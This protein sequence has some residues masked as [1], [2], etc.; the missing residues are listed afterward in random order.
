MTVKNTAWVAVVGMFLL[1]VL[2][3]ADL[4]QTTLGVM[5]GFVPAM[6]LLRSV[7]YAFASATVTVFLLVFYERE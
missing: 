1:T 2:M 4:I 5:R 6:A 3:L 7:I